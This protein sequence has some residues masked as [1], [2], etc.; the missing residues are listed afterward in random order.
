MMVYAE[1][2][3]WPLS[4]KMILSRTIY[5]IIPETMLPNIEDQRELFDVEEFKAPFVKKPLFQN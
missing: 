4:A 1:T 2:G 5:V 3:L